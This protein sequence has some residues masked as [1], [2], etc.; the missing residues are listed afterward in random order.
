MAAQRGRG[1][2][3][4]AAAGQ[5]EFGVVN[6]FAAGGSPDLAVKRFFE[7]HCEAV[8]AEFFTHAGVAQVGNLW[9][10]VLARPGS[11]VVSPAKEARPSAPI[12]NPQPSLN[13][14]EVLQLLNQH[15][16]QP[17]TCGNQAFA[18]AKPLHW[19]DLLAAAATA[20][21]QDMAERNYFSHTSPDGGSMGQRI[22]ATGY[23]YSAAGENIAG[24]YGHE[25]VAQVILRWMNSPGHCANIMNPD[26]R[27]M[28][29]AFAPAKQSGGMGQW[30]LV[31]GLSI[32]NPGH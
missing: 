12:N 28:G 27:D 7:R 10:L 31:L 32:N 22:H 23:A 13:Q 15:R 18:A 14:Q 5:S 6:A 8:K 19:N 9:W 1:L 25:P 20:H 17:Q 11:A 21:A 2:P 3:M 29:L 26:F 16:A 24:A 4:Q 30:V